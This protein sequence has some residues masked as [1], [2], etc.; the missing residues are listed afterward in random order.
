M[1]GPRLCYDCVYF[2]TGNTRTC[3]AFPQKI[4]DEIWN[5]T[6]IH[7]K[8]FSGDH[9]IQFKQKLQNDFLSVTKVANLFKVNSKTIYRALW[10]G[11]LSGYK[12]GKTWRIARKDLEQFKKK[13]IK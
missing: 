12:I 2:D 6:F 13:S 1:P 11:R 5:G 4:P 9:G 7:D 3:G 10:D 8:P